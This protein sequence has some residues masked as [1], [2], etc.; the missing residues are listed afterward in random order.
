MNPAGPR[1]IASTTDL[2][3]DH[4]GTSVADLDRSQAFYDAALGF[5]IVE[6]RF[7]LAAHNL[8]GVV[9]RNRAGARLEL[10]EKA[11]SIPVRAVD[12]IAAAAL[13]GWF[14]LA[15]ATPDVPGQFERIVASG[16]TPVRAPFIAP[17]GRTTVAFVADPDGNLIELIERTA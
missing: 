15:F 4:V 12:P 6:D 5:S 11:D 2:A 7:T 13:H 9:L 8:R 10:F 16:A 17:D 14:Q 3:I 1:A